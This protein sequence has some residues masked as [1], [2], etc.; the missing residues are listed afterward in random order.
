MASYVPVLVPE[1][2]LEEVYRVLARP[3]GLP[4]S[5]EDPERS[6]VRGDAWDP[7]FWLDEANIKEHLR[8]RSR[9]IRGL[10]KYLAS[11]PDEQVTSDEAA[12]AL[13]LKYG[14]NSLAGALGAFGRYC[15]NRGLEFPWE[16][17]Y[18]NPEERAH[19]TLDRRTADVF[20]QLL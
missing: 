1:E 5:P 10:A 16:T 19:L 20:K 6:D 17:S 15:V 11:R 9:T 18:E 4:E 7:D 12:E 14:W 3:V 8:P 2:R 13:G